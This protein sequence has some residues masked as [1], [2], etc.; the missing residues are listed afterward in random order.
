MRRTRRFSNVGQWL[1]V[2]QARRKHDV[3]LHNLSTEEGSLRRVGPY[4][5]LLALQRL[6]GPVLPIHAPNC[7]QAKKEKIEIQLQHG[8]RTEWGGKAVRKK[9]SNRAACCMLHAASCGSWFGPKQCKLAGGVECQSRTCF[10]FILLPRT[11]LGPAV[12]VSRCSWL[13]CVLGAPHFA[14]ISIC[15]ASN[16]LFLALQYSLAVAVQLHDTALP[17]LSIGAL[18]PGAKG[19]SDTRSFRILPVPALLISFVVSE[20]TQRVN[21]L[22]REREKGNTVH[23]RKHFGHDAIVQ[24]GA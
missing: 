6:T 8:C 2:H 13:G 12:Q 19:L 24:K 15:A 1:R 14:I 10:L 16:R 9:Q 20:K 18:P 11:Q 21:P 3:H 22:Q 4:T 17:L 23:R 7:E 5:R